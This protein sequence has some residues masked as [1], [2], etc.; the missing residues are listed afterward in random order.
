MYIPGDN[1]VGG[2]G[3]D[4]KEDT[5]VERFN[6][7]FLETAHPPEHAAVVNVKFVDFLRV[8]ISSRM[9]YTRWLVVGR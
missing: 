7:H 5:K 4:R 1:D 6:Q 8:S 3:F 9:S 2:E